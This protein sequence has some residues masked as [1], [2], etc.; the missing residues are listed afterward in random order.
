[1]RGDAASLARHYAHTS[2]GVTT[3]IFIAMHEK[4]SYLNTVGSILVW[5]F[6]NFQTA[7]LTAFQFLNLYFRLN[8]LLI[9]KF[10]GS[11]HISYP[12]LST[13]SQKFL[14]KKGFV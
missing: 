12:L 13:F 5:I 1:M 10:D 6:H 4:P 11:A 3:M 9:F 14:F 2:E 8:Q 7:Y